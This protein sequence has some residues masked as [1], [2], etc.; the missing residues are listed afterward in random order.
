MIPGL[1]VVVLLALLA[2]WPS[3][4]VR[5]VLQ[6]H[7]QPLESLP[8]PAYLYAEHLVKRYGLVVKVESTADGDHYDPQSKTIRLNEA[9]YSSQSLTAITVA[10]HEFGHALQDAQK[11]EAF[12]RRQALVLRMQKF[13]KI[14]AFA[15]MLSPLMALVGH[16]PIYGFITLMIGVIPM[17]GGV[18]VQFT[19][20]PVEL[21][22]S[23]NKAMPILENSGL[24]SKSQLRDA[25]KI[26]R[27]AA[28][29]YLAG[30]LSSLVDIFKWL[31]G[32][33]R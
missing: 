5:K 16:S 30:A 31:K 28:Y 22:A 6:E 10:A 13:Q 19:T 32:L 4:W 12:Y 27:A 1:V 26:L 3:F 20:L 24:L 29:T 18:L 7:A 11:D 9:H 15:L 8:G 23:F 21:D 25:K 33:R 2:W 17:I 14:S